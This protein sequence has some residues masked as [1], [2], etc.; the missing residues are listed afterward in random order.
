MTIALKLAALVLLLGGAVAE[1]GHLLRAPGV[2]LALGLCLFAYLWFL[3]IAR[4]PI[5][6]APRRRT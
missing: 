3:A 1:T 5:G 2:A 6:P 4:R